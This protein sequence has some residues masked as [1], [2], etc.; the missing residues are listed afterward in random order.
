MLWS[1]PLRDVST[2]W[3]LAM[4]ADEGDVLEQAI[5]W[6][7][8]LSDA[9]P[10]EW[11]LFVSWLEA[12]PEH[13]EIYDGLS[14]D[15]ASLARSLEP[16]KVPAAHPAANDR[17]PAA[18]S[19]MWRSVGGAVFAGAILGGVFAFLRPPALLSDRYVVA[20]VPGETRDVKLA[21][22]SQIDLNGGTRLL[23]DHANPRF[24]KL[25]VGEAIFRVK[26]DASAPFAVRSGNIELRDIGTTFNV[27]REGPRLSV[28][29]SEGAVMF[30]PEREAVVLRSGAQL[31]LREDQD[32]VVIGRVE[33]GA[34]GSWQKGWLV[35]HDT[36]VTNVAAALERAT[37]ARITIAPELADL[38]FTGSI[39]LSGGAGAAVPRFAKLLDVRFTYLNSTW[40]L[41][42][43]QHEAPPG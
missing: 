3:G 6:H 40:S 41:A 14:L 11:H 30:Q 39:R 5:A 28:E 35:L 38:P 13:A 29:V 24:V 10:D 27:T 31:T 26:H 2:A 8:R 34:V 16:L 9:S 37:G 1:F 4:M 17:S 33:P 15:D 21:D 23:L 20:T 36:P 22:G 7:L 25:D 43:R 42:P 32:K 12:D 19:W 18:R